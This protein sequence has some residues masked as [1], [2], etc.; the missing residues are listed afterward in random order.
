MSFTIFQNEKSPFQAIKTKS[1]NSR[2]IEIFPKGLTHGFSPKMS[3]F[4]SQGFVQENVFYDF[5]ERKKAF[6]GYNN[7]KLKSRKFDI[8][9]NPWF[10]SKNGHFSNFFCQAMQTT[11]MTFAIFQNEK[12][13]FQAIK[14]RSSKV[15]KLTFFQTS[16]LIV[17]V[18]KRPFFQ[19]FFFTQY[20]Q[21]K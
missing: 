2:K 15:G 18:Q 5:L 8:F 6:L 10:W 13:P 16:E 7:K 17:L 3:G 14:T 4:V 11:K 1:S 9:S 20:R 19:H 21:G 12:S